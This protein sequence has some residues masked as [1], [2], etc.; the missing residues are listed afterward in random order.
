[1][2]KKNKGSRRG[3]VLTKK[4]IQRRIQ[5]RVDK[6]N[7]AVQI[8]VYVNMRYASSVVQPI[9]K[10]YIDVPSEKFIHWDYVQGR[11]ISMAFPSVKSAI[12]KCAKLGPSYFPIE[13][14]DKL[15]GKNYVTNVKYTLRSPHFG[16]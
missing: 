8:V 4:E 12:I 14:F 7:H 5:N 16:E 11:V 2:P 6:S 1:M 13:Y 9:V 10:A 15:V 3:R